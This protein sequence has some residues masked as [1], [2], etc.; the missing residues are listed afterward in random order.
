MTLGRISEETTANIGV[1]QGGVAKNIVPETTRLV[2]EARSFSEDELARKVEEMVAIAQ[3]TAES[4][5]ARVQVNEV[6]DYPAIRL[7]EGDAVVHFA[8]SAIRKMGLEPRFAKG[9]G[10]SD[11]VILTTKGLPCV[12]LSI[13]VKN[14][15]TS[16]EHIFLE[17]LEKAA[18][19]VFRLLMRNG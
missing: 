2:G 18:Q 10:A 19:L 4:M 12:N 7:D 3:N 8:A 5:G 11:A 6:K 17:E 16:Q 14:A 13:G 15:H 9:G 1:I